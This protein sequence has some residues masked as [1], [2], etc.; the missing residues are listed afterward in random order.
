MNIE[1]FREYCLSFPSTTED[2]PFDDKTLVFKVAGKMFALCG[3]EEFTGFNVK[4]DPVKA[5]ELRGKYHSIRP[6]YHMNK[7][8]WNTIDITGE[9]SEQE[10]QHWIRHS[11]ELVVSKLPKAAKTEIYKDYRP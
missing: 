11:Y 9:L 3:I 7:K 10:L 1:S 2:M 6:G 8:H 4:C 5:E